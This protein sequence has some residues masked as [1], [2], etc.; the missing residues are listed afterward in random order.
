[1]QTLQRKR[2]QTRSRPRKK[3]CAYGVRVSRATI[4]SYVG[5]DPLSFVDPEGLQFLDLTT[6][7]GV[8]RNTTL[9]DAVRAGAWTRTVSLPAVTAGLTPSVIG[10]VGSASAPLFCPVTTTVTS[11]APA[12]VAVPDLVAGRWVIQGGPSTWNYI[13]TGVWGPRYTLGEGFSWQA[14]PIS[15]SVTGT[16]TVGWPSGI[17]NFWRGIFGQR[18]VIQ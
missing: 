7:A 11:W 18:Q 4:F 16:A 10:L 13:R 8:R 6:I 15:N 3:A 5:G 1:M 2:C 9:D 12:S 17:A 14:Y